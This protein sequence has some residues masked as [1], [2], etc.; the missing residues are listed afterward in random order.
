MKLPYRRSGLRTYLIF[1]GII[2]NSSTSL[3]I[4]AGLPFFIAG[5]IIRLWAKGCLHQN[6]ELTISGPYGF[7]RHPFYLGNLMLDFA[8]VIMSGFIPLILIFP[9]LWLCVYIPTMKREERVLIRLFGESYH[10]YQKNTPMLIPYKRPLK[11]KG[12]FSWNNP[13]ICKTEVPRT[14]RFLC[15]P[16]IFFLVYLLRTQGISGFCSSKA[17]ITCALIISFY[18][19]SWEIRNHFAYSKSILP[20]FISINKRLF[21][22]TGI[23]IFGF[24]INW[25]ELEYD[26]IVWPL[27]ISLLSISFFI[28]NPIESEWMIA[29]GL[30]V[31]FELIWFALI[32]SPIYLGFFLDNRSARIKDRRY[33]KLLLLTIGLLLAASKEIEL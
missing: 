14:I 21:V 22:L 12:G 11:N 5:I 20:F 2:A 7:V 25:A 31:L 19:I 28:K 1:I 27:G 9:F 4:T 10:E 30:S 26:H 18:V 24:F 3:W 6:R 32:I 16:F 15:Y 33:I 29:T 13:N 8:I 23:I 17:I